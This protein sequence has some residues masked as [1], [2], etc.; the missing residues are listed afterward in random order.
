M[1]LK[2]IL[3]DFNG[4]LYFDNRM[5]I[6]IF[7][8]MLR[9][10]G[11]AE[12]EDAYMI[13]KIFGRDNETIFR[14]NVK[15]HATAAEIAAFVE[16]KENLY[17]Q[18]CRACPAMSSLV[19]GAEELLNYLKEKDIPYCMATGSD[20]CNVEFYFD[21]LKL[22]RWFTMDNI[23]YCDKTYPGKPAPDIYRIAAAR[24]GLD[25][26]ECLVFEDGTSGILSANGAGAGAVVLV[27]EEGYPS[28]LN[29]KTHVNRSFHD[30]TKWRSVLSDFDLL[31]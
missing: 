27:H 5:H 30:F 10:L 24:I 20:L 23:V 11:V 17:Q 8:L 2:G 14:Q 16:R 26:S 21:Y 13:E 3:F 18:L 1:K 31:R 25:P 6:D 22:D 28:P 29:E 19:K 4:T 15:E 12:H 9:E 7:N